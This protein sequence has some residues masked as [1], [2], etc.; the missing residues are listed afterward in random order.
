MKL[1]ARALA[2]ALAVGVAGVVALARSAGSQPA[3]TN[4]LE[5]QSGNIPFAESK[6]RADLYDALR[7]DYALGNGRAGIRFELDRNSE[8]RFDYQAVTE[9]WAEWSDP[10]LRVR[11]GNAYTILGRGLVH[12]SFELPGVV[13]DQPGVR[14]RYAPSRDVD[15]VL[16]EGTWGPVAG[17]L[18]GGTP[19]S[20]QF[21]AAP[22]N[23]RFGL[24]RYQGRLA[25]GQWSA[26]LWREA[27]VGVAYLRTSNGFGKR[28]EYGSGFVELDPLRMA[29][30]GDVS[31]PIYVEYAQ[32][33][34]PVADW[35][36]F[37]TGDRDTFALYASTQLLWGAFALA[38]EWK[39][40]REFR[41]GI[42]DPPSLVREHGFAL[43]NRGTHVLDAA[44]ERGF[45]LEGS[46]TGRS[47]GTLTANLSRSDGRGDRFDERYL[48]VHA[49][50][51]GDPRWE[52]TL[53][54]DEGKDE[55][56]FISARR[57]T[58]GAATVRFRAG[59]AASVDLEQQEA[60]RELVGLP[61]ATFDDR[62][63]SLT[64]S[65]AG[66][67][68]VSLIRERSTDPEQ[69]DP[70][71]AIGDEVDART[72]WAGVVQ[73]TISR[74]HEGT[75]F[76]GERRGGRACTAGTCYEVQPFK[77]VELR[78]VTRL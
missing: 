8:G 33:N 20:G 7:I 64:A 29:G 42:N 55:F 6:H 46:W 9:R 5:A 1:G 15:G 38:A 28:D 67:G 71:L 24:P 61:P 73:A 14:S 70:A 26:T 44:R 74:H 37:R 65:R 11:V 22:E 60:T 52:A 19:N 48:E 54:W 53:F 47:W 58:G 50:P 62:H 34:R 12:R 4:L 66:L 49:V 27:R 72:F 16:V 45:Q 40:Y 36:R 41:L 23:E 57:V 30:V 76:V 77:G 43:L 32:A 18:L 69:E 59:W 51:D 39:D 31:L 35:G 56:S 17:R 68:S 75:L 25:G 10:R 3:V 63:A 78:L 2:G 13:L 21:S